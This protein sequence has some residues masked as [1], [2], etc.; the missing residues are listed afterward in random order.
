MANLNKA[1][2]MSAAAVGHL[3][4]QQHQQ[5]Q[6]QQQQH[7]RTLVQVQGTPTEKRA[8]WMSENYSQNIYAVSF[9]KHKLPSR[10]LS[11]FFYFAQKFQYVFHLISFKRTNAIMRCF[12]AQQVICN[13]FC[14]FY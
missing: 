4:Q 11:L 3:Q 12:R 1:A 9:F 2:A 7:Q 6:Q 13:M 5:Q 10:K 8:R 14:E